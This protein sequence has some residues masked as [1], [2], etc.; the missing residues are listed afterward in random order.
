MR[1][2]AFDPL[3]FNDQQPWL[4]PETAASAALKERNR[5]LKAYRAEHGKDSA[6]GWRLTGQ[7]RPYASFGVPD[8]RVRTVYYITFQSG[9]R[10]AWD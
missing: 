2:V 8:G 1:Q 9:P 6:Y 4:T 10:A 3:D 7:L 5:K